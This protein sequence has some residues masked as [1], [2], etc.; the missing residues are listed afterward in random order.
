MV[1]D[2][3]SGKKTPKKFFEKKSSKNMAP[4]TPDLHFELLYGNYQL[5]EKDR[6]GI[7]GAKNL[8]LVLDSV[9]KVTH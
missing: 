6:Q 1:N 7:L 5:K 2:K 3:K 8:T 4:V 9:Q